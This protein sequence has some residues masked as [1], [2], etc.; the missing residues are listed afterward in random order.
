[1]AYSGKFS[2]KHINKYKGKVNKIEY[3]SLWEKSMMDWCDGNQH[4]ISWSSEE[5]IIPYRST[6][7]NDKMRR[8]FMDFWVRFDSGDEYIF[9]VKPF[10][11][12]QPPTPPKRNTPKTRQRFL[13]EIYTYTVNQDKWKAAMVLAHKKGWRF[14]VLT[15]HGLRK[16][17][18][19]IL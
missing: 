14:K 12:T 16:L 8:Y 19:K 11:E 9:E 13:N 15:E 6:A 5:V 2:P 4:V 10:K 1:M 7:D 17:G 3:R 18:M